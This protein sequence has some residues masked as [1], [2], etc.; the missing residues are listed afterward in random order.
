MSCLGLWLECDRGMLRMY[1]NTRERQMVLLE[2]GHPEKGHQFC[3][4]VVLQSKTTNFVLLYF[5]SYDKFVVNLKHL[6]SF[7]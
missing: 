1:L 5:Y 7:L 4:I 3:M 2:G 6:C